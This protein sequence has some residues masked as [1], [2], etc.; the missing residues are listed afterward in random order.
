M[1]IE[2]E[3]SDLKRLSPLRSLPHTNVCWRNLDTNRGAAFRGS[4]GIARHPHKS[5]NFRPP[6]NWRIIPLLA[7]ARPVQGLPFA[8]AHCE[9]P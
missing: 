8:R 2:P 3:R 4:L 1:E 9:V 5:R 7:S 6:G